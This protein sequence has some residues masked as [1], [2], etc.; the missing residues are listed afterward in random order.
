MPFDRV[1]HHAFARLAEQRANLGAPTG[2]ADPG[3]AI[4]DQPRGVGQAGFQQRDQAQLGRGRVAARHGD[5]AGLADLL[6]VHFRQAVDSLVEQ[7]RSAMR[8]AVPARPLLGVRQAEVSGQ[9]DDPGPGVQQFA[10]QRV[11][12]AVR[13]GEEHHVAGA[14][15]LRVRHAELQVVIM[16][17]QV[18]VHVGD[19]HPRLGTRSDHFHP[20]LRMLRQQ[21]QQFHAR[22]TRTA[23]DADLDHLSI[24][25]RAEA[26]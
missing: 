8:L 13:R 14:E 26:S 4:G 24:T 16:T 17:S 21:A 20:G 5:Q 25:P 12:H 6:A 1:G 11:R 7:R 3:L 23:N 18:R 9:I 19:L 10:S 22:I 2:T 15:A